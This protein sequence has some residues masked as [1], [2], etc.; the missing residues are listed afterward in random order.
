MELRWPLTVF[1]FFPQRRGKAAHCVSPPTKMR[2]KKSLV[3][4]L[5]EDTDNS[6]RLKHRDE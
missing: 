3:F 2:K 6:G 1:P 4:K 5:S